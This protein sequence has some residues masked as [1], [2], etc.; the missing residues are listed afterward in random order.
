MKLVVLAAVAM[1]MAGCV[2]RQAEVQKQIAAD[3]EIC[4]SQTFPTKVA[5]ARC[6]NSAEQKMSAVYDKPDLL[7]LRLAS[8]LAIAEKQDKGQ[9]SDAQAEL[10][11]AQV[12]AQI[13]TQE[14]T[15][16][17]NAEMASAASAA[18]SPRRVTCSRI[19]NSVTC[20]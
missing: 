20:F 12:G 13:G 3:K 15:R 10:E 8:R 1:A 11:F 17:S 9:I 6:I 18:A 19:G 4:R 5:F 2:S 14:A 16:N 7:Q